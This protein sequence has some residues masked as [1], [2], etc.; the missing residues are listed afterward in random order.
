MMLKARYILEIYL[1]EIKEEM[2]SIK[3]EIQHLVDNEDSLLISILY[4]GKVRF[5]ECR[6]YES[7]VQ[8]G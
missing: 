1:E 5:L 6:G 7:F 4:A 8:G 2:I 3:E